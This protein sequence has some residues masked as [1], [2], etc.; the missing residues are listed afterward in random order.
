MEKLQLECNGLGTKRITPTG[1]KESPHSQ[2]FGAMGPMNPFIVAIADSPDCTH[3]N[4]ELPAT[5]M[6]LQSMPSNM[7]FLVVIAECEIAI[8][9]MVCKA[10]SM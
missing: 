6:L 7:P 5:S 4:I 10:T 3:A 8:Y 2:P 1:H 9:G